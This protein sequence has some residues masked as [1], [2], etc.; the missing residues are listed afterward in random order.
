MLVLCIMRA[1]SKTTQQLPPAGGYGWIGG[2]AGSER[3]C[4]RSISLA[5]EKLGGVE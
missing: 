4:V 3:W 5:I 2:Q 1:N